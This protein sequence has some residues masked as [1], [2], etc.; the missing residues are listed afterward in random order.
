[1]KLKVIAILLMG[2]FSVNA[3]SAETKKATKTVRG[4][5]KKTEKVIVKEPVKQPIKEIA[6][7]TVIDGFESGDWTPA[8]GEGAVIKVSM[9]PGKDGKALQIDYDLKESKQWVSVSKNIDPISDFS[10]KA[11]QFCMKDNCKKV[12]NLEVKLLDEDGTTYGF[13]LPIKNLDNWETVTTDI[14]DFSYWWGGDNKLGPIKRIEFA[15]GYKDGD[16]GM[17]LLDNLKI[18]PST[19]KNYETGL[20]NSCDSLDGWINEGSEGTSSKLSLIPG[21]VN[22]AVSLDYDIGSADGWVQFHKNFL[23]KLTNKSVFGFFLKWSGNQNN[24]EFKLADKDNSTFGKKFENLQKKDEWQLIE[25]PVSELTYFFGGD[26]E[27]DMNNIAGIW[28]AVT[29]SQGG[30]GSV[31]IDQLSF[32]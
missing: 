8:N 3:F 10:R 22:Q 21:K 29:K 30:K 2:F 6:V 9:V 5:A 18:V 25:I 7:G 24:I 4:P 15:I 28:I 11:I 16:A 31:A 26:K 19:K 1:M 27:L 14:S 13:R 12:N 17:I 23:I 20:L 32:E